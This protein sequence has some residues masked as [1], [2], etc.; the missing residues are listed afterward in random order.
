MNYLIEFMGVVWACC[1]VALADAFGEPA[2]DDRT[3][4]HPLVQNA[5]AVVLPA[6]LLWPVSG[7]ARR[8]GIE[9]IEIPSA[10]E[11]GEMDQLL[12]MV[13]QAKGPVLSQDLTLLTLAGK[14]VEYQPCD[15][16]HMAYLGRWDQRDFV[17]HI[18][19]QRYALI[20]LGFD[21][22]TSQDLVG[23]TPQMIAAIRDAY[24]PSGVLAHHWIYTPRGASVP[25]A[26]RPPTTDGPTT[27]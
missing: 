27:D 22:R 14:P 13:R 7:F 5:A 17:E 1:A 8:P 25:Y 2:G 9:W 26:G 16:P 3:A 12:Q 20:V 19:H 18:E 23:F 24:A 15:L 4:H 10:E 11:Q 21:V 6:L